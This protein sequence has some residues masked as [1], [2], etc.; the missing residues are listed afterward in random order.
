[1]VL[2]RSSGQKPAATTNGKNND[3]NDGDDDGDDG[4]EEYDPQ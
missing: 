1:M 3:E 4:E 2:L